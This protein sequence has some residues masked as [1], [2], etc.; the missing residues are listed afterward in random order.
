[1][2]DRFDVSLWSDLFPPTGLSQITRAVKSCTGGSARVA[3]G[4]ILIAMVACCRAVKPSAHRM[5]YPSG[6]VQEQRI[7]HVIIL[8]IDGLNQE[9][10]LSYLQR[11][12][13]ERT[14]GY[15]ICSA[16]A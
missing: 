4:F 12:P 7:D 15:M 16:C 5:G 9:T 6:T 2:E 14:G 11:P 8:A 10:L 1:M 13:G 3:N